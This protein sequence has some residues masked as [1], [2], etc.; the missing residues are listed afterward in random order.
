[1]FCQNYEKDTPPEHSIGNDLGQC[2]KLNTPRA[3]QALLSLRPLNLYQPPA[4]SI[5]P[6]TSE[7]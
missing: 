2:F 5:N 4:I 3:P 7:A 1:M 6:H